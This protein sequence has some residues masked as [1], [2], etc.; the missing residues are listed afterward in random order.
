M[1]AEEQVPVV[2]D[3]EQ[4][5]DVVLSNNKTR[6]TRATVQWSML[7]QNKHHEVEHPLTKG[8][9]TM[10]LSDTRKEHR[11]EHPLTKG[12]HTME[13][14]YTRKQHRV[15]HPVTNDIA[16]GTPP[17]FFVKFFFK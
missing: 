1:Q 2:V 8:H 5:V 11:V 3:K 10:E 4:G 6:L 7:S 15:E 12:H 17:P 16:K 13:L 14:S 9:H